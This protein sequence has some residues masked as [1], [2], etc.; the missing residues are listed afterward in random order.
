MTLQLADHSIIKPHGVVED[1]LVKVRQF[2]FPV[3]FVIIDIEEDYDIP[4][5]L[6]N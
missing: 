2:T 3:D 5:I 1:V 4:L 6:G